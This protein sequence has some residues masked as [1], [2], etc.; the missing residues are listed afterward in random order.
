MLLSV[1]EYEVIRLVD[2]EKQNHEQCAAVMDISRTTVTEIYERVRYKISDCLVNG[3][4]LVISGGNY[5]ICNGK[6]K[7][8]CGRPCLKYTQKHENILAKGRKEMKVAVTYDNGEIFQHFGHTQQFKV[9]EVENGVITKSDV[10]DSNGKGHGAL[11]G[12]LAE[13]GIEVLIC[14]GIGAGAQ[15]ALSDAGIKLY[16]GVSGG[17]DEAVLDLINGTIGYNPDVQCNHHSH[18]DRHSLGEHDCGNGGCH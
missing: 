1:D 6:H 2:F 16:G 4:Q 14:G 17:A 8:C 5:R 9:Y 3:K 18:E 7:S 10:M 11:A 12:L 13:S 15:M